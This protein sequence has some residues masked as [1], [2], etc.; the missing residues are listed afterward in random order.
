MVDTVTLDR[1]THQEECSDGFSDIKI[2][3]LVRL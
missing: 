3:S 1:D 2:I